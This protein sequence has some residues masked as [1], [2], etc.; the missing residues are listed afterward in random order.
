MISP[1]PGA[2]LLKD[3]SDL[4]DL[5]ARQK[6]S[7]YKPFPTLQ[8][9]DTQLAV[10][11]GSAALERFLGQP[12][13]SLSPSAF[14]AANNLP[15]YTQQLNDIES[16]AAR[17]LTLDKSNR[18]LANLKLQ[19]P[20]GQT[21]LGKLPSYPYDSLY[22][23]VHYSPSLNSVSHRGLSDL[24][25]ASDE[26][27][28][29]RTLF[30]NRLLK[31][32]TQLGVL[33]DSVATQE[34]NPYAPGTT[35]IEIQPGKGKNQFSINN[36]PFIT[37]PQL[38]YDI[39][40]ND[41]NSEDRDLFFTF[42]NFERGI[43]Q[44]RDLTYYQ[45]DNKLL[46]YGSVS[47]FWW[48]NFT[49]D[50][51]NS[52]ANV[53]SD[54]YKSRQL[55][56]NGFA[57]PFTTSIRID[58]TIAGFVAP[59]DSLYID[60]GD[61][62]FD[63][64]ENYVKQGGFGNDSLLGTTGNDIILGRSGNDSLVGLAGDDLFSGGKGADSFVLNAPKQGFDQILDF[65]SAEGDKVVI[66]AAAFGGGLVAGRALSNLDVLV[67]PEASQATTSTH[68]LIYDNKNGLLWFDGD[69][70]GTKFSSV[71]MAMFCG[72]AALSISSF[73]IAA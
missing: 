44:I 54:I 32:I 69:G 19:D 36:G 45:V 51:D 50:N 4:R 63:K 73:T 29:T 11:Y 46:Y 16:F 41:K 72:S 43:A 14:W 67:A 5:A 71:P 40:S 24:I 18:A 26:Y 70:T 21:Q 49:F 37:V 59:V 48:D 22:R 66:S 7:S 23:H 68:R 33:Y 6:L 56:Q 57:E 42:G 8:P 65:S 38:S 31:H 28:V 64:T 25:Q 27:A 12:G 2:V 13:Q 10:P 47:F 3:E 9:L 20:D 60:L 34:G 30:Q 15:T 39:Q 17:R 55:Q 62:T 61:V 35:P 1:A 53:Q 58:D 52:L